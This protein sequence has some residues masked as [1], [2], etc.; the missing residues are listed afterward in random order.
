MNGVRGRLLPDG[1]AAQ[2][3][4]SVPLAT[5]E[6]TACLPLVGAAQAWRGLLQQLAVQWQAAVA[7]LGPLL[8]Q[9]QEALD[10]VSVRLHVGQVRG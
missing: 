6:A 8:A 2:G 5:E 9:P 4:G 7:Q 3:R 1:A 10:I